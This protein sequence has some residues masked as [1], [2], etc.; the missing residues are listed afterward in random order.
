MKTCFLLLKFFTYDVSLPG[1][2]RE[3]YE[4]AKK[5]IS[6]AESNLLCDFERSAMVNMI[7]EDYKNEAEALKTDK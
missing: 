7:A 1:L 4:M 6:L 2:V 5:G 3:Q